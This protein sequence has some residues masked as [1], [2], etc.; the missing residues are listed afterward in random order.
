MANIVNLN[1]ANADSHHFG[2]PVRAE[3]NA[4]TTGH[5]LDSR[6][7]K[8]RRP[9]GSSLVAAQPHP[10]PLAGLDEAIGRAAPERPGVLGH[11]ITHPQQPGQQQPEQ[12]GPSAADEREA[13]RRNSA[14]NEHEQRMGQV[15]GTVD[16]IGAQ[17]RARTRSGARDYMVDLGHEVQVHRRGVDIDGNGDAFGPTGVPVF[18]NPNPPSAPMSARRNPEPP[19]SPLAARR[20]PRTRQVPPR[21]GVF[22]ASRPRSRA[23]PTRSP[24][25]SPLAS[26]KWQVPYE[27][28]SSLPHS[29]RRVLGGA[30]Q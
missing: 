6:S 25:P 9:G 29:A 18:R 24:R 12:R 21:C 10:G 16:R 5:L 13:Y 23:R 7:P 26:E 19:T 20:N 11:R 8:K 22:P 30:G 2:R 15:R 27:H 4:N 17:D 3:D 1:S 14:Y 28:P